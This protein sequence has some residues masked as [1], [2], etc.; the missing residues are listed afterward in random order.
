MRP[1][2]EAASV[3]EQSGSG[4]MA[5]VRQVRCRI[6]G[7]TTDLSGSTIQVPEETSG[8]LRETCIVVYQGICSR[9]QEKLL[10]K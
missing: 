2:T 9:C 8:F 6:C 3:P 5:C 10:S 4:Q 7:Q 1:D